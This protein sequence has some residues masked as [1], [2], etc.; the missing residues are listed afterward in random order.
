MLV[1]RKHI[2]DAYAE[3]FSA[4]EW[5]QIPVYETNIKRS[6]YHAFLLRIK[7]ITEAQR[8]EIIREI[9]HR[10]VSVNVHFVPLPM[11]TYYKNAGYS[12][13]DYPV[14][15]DNYSREISLPVYYDLTDEM[16]KTVV[17]AVTGAVEE[18]I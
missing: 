13:S 3:A 2:F 17:M 7:G 6:S 4:F 5:A 1:R 16:V 18:V 10:E 14:A 12:I 15:F 9:F 11:M 8:D